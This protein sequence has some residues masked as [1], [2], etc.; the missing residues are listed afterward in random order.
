MQVL[1]CDI[2]PA[3]VQEATEYCTCAIEADVTDRFHPGKNG[4]WEF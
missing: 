1:C 2:N 3:L 4:T